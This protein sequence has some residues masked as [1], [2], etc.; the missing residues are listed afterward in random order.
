MKTFKHIVAATDFSQPSEQAV[1]LA[2]HLARTFNASLTLVHVFQ[3]PAA[4]YSESALY[5]GELVEPVLEEAEATLSQTVRAITGEV[6]QV[7]ATIRQGVPYEQILATA[8]ELGA[9]LIVM[10]TRGRTGLAHIMLGSVAE[11]VVRLSPIPVLTVRNGED[12][13][14]ATEETKVSENRATT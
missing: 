8:K 12:H 11:K 2:T 13:I 9:D 1:A 10:G 7:S 14:V 6:S 4:L 5:S 3:Y